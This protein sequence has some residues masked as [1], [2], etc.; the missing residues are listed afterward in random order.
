ML[1]TTITLLINL[2][3]GLLQSV[4]V[5]TPAMEGLIAKLGAAVPVLI[6]SIA[7]GKS[8]PDDVLAVLTAFQ[9]EIRAMQTGTN[10]SPDDLAIA[11]TLDQAITDALIAH[12]AAGKIT[13]P[14]TLTPLPTNL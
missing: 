4:G 1:L 6:T 9:T 7:Q 12:E 2:L 14:S 3:P 8:I 13:D 11:A 10:L 5:I